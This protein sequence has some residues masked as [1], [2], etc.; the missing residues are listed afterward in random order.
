MNVYRKSKE[1]DRFRRRMFEAATDMHTTITMYKAMSIFNDFLDEI[2]GWVSAE[3]VEQI[4]AEIEQ[5]KP[6]DL[7]CDKRTPE[8]IRDMAL[9]IIDKYTRGERMKVEYNGNEVEQKDFPVM[10][11]IDQIKAEIA[12]EVSKHYDE[13]QYVAGLMTAKDIF[14]KHMKGESE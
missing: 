12:E 10:S 13:W 3:A 11:V 7:P 9:Q 6:Y 5:I 14:E 4:R 8:H 2:R 1:I